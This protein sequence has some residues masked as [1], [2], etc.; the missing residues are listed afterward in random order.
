MLIYNTDVFFI[1]VCYVASER[2]GRVW[3]GHHSQ[4]V[5]ALFMDSQMPN[6]PNSRFLSHTPNP[7][8]SNPWLV[9]FLETSPSSSLDPYAILLENKYIIMRFLQ[10]TGLS[11]ISVTHK[12]LHVVFHLWILFQPKPIYTRLHFI[13]PFIF[14]HVF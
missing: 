7:D 3:S 6:T 14:L 8:N 11:K 9:S 1:I 10:M 4:V 2:N 13:W 12:S 5:L